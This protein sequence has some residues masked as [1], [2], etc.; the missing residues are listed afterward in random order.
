MNILGRPVLLRR[1]KL[2]RAR[3]MAAHVRDGYG[4]VRKPKF[5]CGCCEML[6]C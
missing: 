5:E 1:G 2:P 4:A 6:S 3:G